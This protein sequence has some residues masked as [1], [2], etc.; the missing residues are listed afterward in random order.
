MEL[1]ASGDASGKGVASAV[2]TVVVQEK[3]VN[4]GLVA[5]R[6][7]LAKKEL[8]IPR[9]VL[10]SGHMAVNLLSNV[11]EALEGFPVSVK[12]CWL[13]RMSGQ[14]SGPQ[15]N[16]PTRWTIVHNRM[17]CQSWSRSTSKTMTS[18]SVQST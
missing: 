10:V 3:G 8:T 1:H 16:I 15:P 4:Q 9:L 13:D 17:Y 2:Y 6:A 11:S 5:L 18:A 14:S 7:R 12:Y